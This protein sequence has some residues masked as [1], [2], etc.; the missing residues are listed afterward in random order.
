MQAIEVIAQKLE[1][2]GALCPQGDCPDCGRVHRALASLEGALREVK[3][4]SVKD[5]L[6]QREEWVLANTEDL[7]RAVVCFQGRDWL[8]PSPSEDS[9]D[10]YLNFA[11]VDKWMPLPE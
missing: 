3:W 1:S 9:R 8:Y 7:G 2:S 11:S 5:R 6:P 10:C 4:I